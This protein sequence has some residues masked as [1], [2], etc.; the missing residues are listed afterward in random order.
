[1][2]GEEASVL[3]L[4]D[5]DSVVTLAPSQDHK[6]IFDN[7]AGPNTGGM[8]AY[9]PAPVVSANLM[10]K[11]TNTVIKP[12]LQEMSKIGSPY[13]GVLYAGLMIKEDEP[14]VLEFNVR[15]GDPETQAILPRLDS[16]LAKALVTV[17]DEKLDEVELAWKKESCICTVLASGGYPGEY[18][19][20]REITGL[21][22]LK[23]KKDI[24]VFHAG[25]KFEDSKILTN[26]GRV[27][28]VS[29]LGEDIKGAIENVYGA[30]SQINFEGMHYRRDIGARALK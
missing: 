12:M 8:G 28:G 10:K 21:D 15:F 23:D 9:S 14:K 3:A 6:R 1:M 25:T 22:S 5:G 27:L 18:Q 19:K 26:G 7:D 30:V 17:I 13:K 16:D 24:V 11:I 29:A 2:E 20:G 4:T